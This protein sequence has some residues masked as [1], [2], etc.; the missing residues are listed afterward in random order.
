M[1]NRKRM[2]RSS[3][4]FAAMLLMGHPA[5]GIGAGPLLITNVTIIDVE[6]GSARPAQTVVVQGERIVGIADVQRT[7]LPKDAAIIDGKG[8]FLVP[9][10]WDMHVHSHREQRWT[11]HYPLFIAHGVTGVRDAGT[12]LAS[13]LSEMQRSR[14]DALA[15]TVIWGT[16][17]LDGLTPTLSFGLGI[18]SEDAAA[19]MVR[20]ARRLGFDFIKTY[21]R[22]AP[23][24]YLALARTAAL[25]QMRIEG[26]VP[27]SM[28]PADVTTA[29]HDLID[30]LTLVVEACTPGA[31]EHV[32]ARAAAA[33]DTVDSM[34]LMMDPQLGRLLDGFD[35]GACDR[36]FALLAE[37]GVQQVPTLVQAR[38]YFLPEE[39]RHAAQ[40]RIGETTPALMSEWLAHE[41]ES[42][43]E[44]LAAGAAVYSRQLALLRHMQD[45]G[46]SLMTGT[47]VS[48]E[49]WVFAGSG[50]H[51]EMALFVEAGLTPLE[52]LQAATLRPL[53]YAGRAVGGRAIAAGE[54]ADLVLLNADPRADIDN[55]RRIHAVIKRG[56][57]YDHAALDALVT[58]AREAAAKGGT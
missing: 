9:G 31:L 57:Q 1:L 25:E 28:S 12:H 14:A 56:R 33:P 24:A 29:G 54:V 45:A 13:A 51:D 15:P 10:F 4:V 6:D 52:A 37:R 42:T 32:H 49:T 26:H 39:S 21:D 38:G 22:L 2:M 5:A 11:Y 46:V 17:P 48:S 43:P 16:P 19:E 47:D 8:R 35:A 55:T 36:L 23:G 53:R 30:H 41:R 7:S 34:G 58:Q 40:A 50:V 44:E 18:E 3:L 20:L 27:L